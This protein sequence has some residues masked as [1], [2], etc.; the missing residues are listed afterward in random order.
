MQLS[1]R[2]GQTVRR[3]GALDGRPL[4]HVSR[5]RLFNLG[6]MLWHSDSSFRPIPVKYSETPTHITPRVDFWT[7][8][9]AKHARRPTPIAL[10]FSIRLDLWPWLRKRGF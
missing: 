1:A 6:N 10:A 7:Q 9:R 2:K 3:G 8:G 5:R 4:A